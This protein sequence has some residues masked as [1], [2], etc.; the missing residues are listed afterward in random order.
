SVRRRA[1]TDGR[2]DLI[3]RPV[4]D[5]GLLVRGDVRRVDGTEGSLVLTSAAVHWA[6]LLGV[7]TAA[8]RGPEH[9]LPARNHVRT[10]RHLSQGQR[11]RRAE[12]E[13]QKPDE[14]KAPRAESWQ[15]DHHL[16]Q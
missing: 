7:A 15:G 6:I 9:V 11:R 10:G 2:D 13:G 1:E 14:T 16:N 8:A 3:V 12:E 5:P 4:A